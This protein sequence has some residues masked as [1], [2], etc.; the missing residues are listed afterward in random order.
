MNRFEKGR[1][2]ARILRRLLPIVVFCAVI[3]LFLSG[4]SSVSG[5]ASREEARSLEDSILK[6]AVHCYALEGF[7]P[8]DIGYL[9][10]NYGISY[11]RD[12][13]VVSYEVIGENM[14]PDIMV[15]PL[16]SKGGDD[17]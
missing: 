4:L 9:E 8:E 3:L 17:Q 1:D 7:Y 13:Y 6:S 16:K 12:K 10:D 2:R 15:I 11:D 14:M 5:S